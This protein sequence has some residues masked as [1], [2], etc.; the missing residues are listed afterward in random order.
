MVAFIFFLLKVTICSAVL[1]GY[2]WFFL[3]NKVFHAYNRFYL[4]AIVVLSVT[5]P[6]IKI[7]IFHKAAEP[8]TNIIK[9]LQVVTVG[10][11]YIDEVIISPKRS[12]TI[13]Q[14]LPFIYLLVSFV[15]LLM[16]LQMLIHIASLLRKNKVMLI[17]DIHFVNTDNAK[18]TPFSFFKYIFW[19]QQIDMQSPAGARIF[20][21][22]M[23]H[24]QER[25][26]WDKMFINTVLIAFWIN[27]VFWLI[28][29]ELSL[30]HEFIADKRAVETGDTAAFAAMILAATYP[31]QRIGITNNFFYS[32]IKR[33]L[34]MLTKNQ[35]P[36]MNYISRLLVLPL[37]VIVFAAFTLKAKTIDDPKNNNTV[38]NKI[39]SLLTN[40]NSSAGPENNEPG[41]N[42]VKVLFPTERKIRV[43]LDAGHGGIDAGGKGADGTTEKDLS[44]Q[45]TK[46]IKAL[47]TNPNVEIILTRE[48]DIYQTPKEKSAFANEQ[49]ADLFISVHIDNAL[50]KEAYNKTGM[51]VWIARDSF[52]NSLASKLFA[53]AIIG[54]FENN[55]GLDVPK[56]PMQ[57]KAGIW[58]L[59][60]TKAPSVLI[61]AGYI[62]NDKDRVYLKSDKGQEAFAI[63]VLNALNDYATG[64]YTLEEMPNGSH[65]TGKYRAEASDAA[66]ETTTNPVAN[67][68]QAQ[69]PKVPSEIFSKIEKEAE[70]PGGKQAYKNFLQK[71][72]NANVPVAEGWKPG[73]YTVMLKFIINA[74]GEVSSVQTENYKGTK[75]SEECIRL[76][77]TSPKWVPAMQNGHLVA[78][79]KKQPITFIV[80]E[81]KDDKKIVFKPKNLSNKSTEQAGYSQPLI[82]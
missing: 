22:E 66:I 71:N 41:P 82:I 36:K 48:G 18:G 77:K 20:K 73:T 25:H 37:A 29:R 27:P 50:Q 63:N 78:S 72:L 67:N 30:I 15:L 49:I 65:A 8:K 16:M 34:M 52:S 64:K 68:D 39:A 75:T 79:Y 45:L 3:R 17:E 31:Q 59:Q 57:R 42:T 38:T 43:V 60:A 62:S 13:E 21:H 10:D 4:L 46:K 2:Y 32:P 69:Q 28:R 53:S 74:K 80:E 9:M 11:E 55:Y 47:N 14:I 12:I 33:R 6:L 26:S 19:N 40:T 81:Q 7:N 23:A 44:L 24:I 61:E 76:M 51:S 1:F 58:V 5:L 70:F 54:R 56:S 35:H